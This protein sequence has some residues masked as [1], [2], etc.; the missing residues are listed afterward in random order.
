MSVKPSTTTFV[1]T[2]STKNDNFIWSEAHI[3]KNYSTSLYKNILH[4]S[5]F[6]LSL[7]FI[8]FPPVTLL[9]LHE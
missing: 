8:F 4:F 2:I 1:N 6:H 3:S 7:N 5:R 9:D